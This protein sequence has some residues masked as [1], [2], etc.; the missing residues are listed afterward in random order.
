MRN[1]AITTVAAALLTPD[2]SVGILGVPIN[3]VVACIAGTFCSFV[4]GE[5]VEP[6]S[7]MW[8]LFIACVIMGCA[9]TGF[10]V[11]MVEHWILPEGKTVAP[12]VFAS[13]GAIVSC[14]TRFFIP[15]LIDKV[16][17]GKWIDII[18]NKEK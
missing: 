7:Y 2:L 3:I 1:L 12:G 16:K 14:V 4:F 13:L 5:A 10:S 15:W 18:R 11:A 17:T 9:L 6:R 8:K